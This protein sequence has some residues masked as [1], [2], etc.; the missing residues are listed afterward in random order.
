VGLKSP[1][2]PP[3]NPEFQLPTP[4]PGTPSTGFA[5]YFG[6][7]DHAALAANPVYY[8]GDM[9]LRAATAIDSWVAMID[10]RG[11]SLSQVSTDGRKLQSL[12][13]PLGLGVIAPG[14]DF[15]YAS[16]VNGDGLEDLIVGGLTPALLI[17]QECDAARAAAL[18]CERASR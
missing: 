2:P 6:S 15:A 7:A 10:N 17:Q 12:S 14:V 11:A 3:D 18:Q 5:V 8:P 4:P 1:P 9:T 16:D 13:T